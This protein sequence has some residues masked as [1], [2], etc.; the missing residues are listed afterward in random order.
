MHEHGR[1]QLVAIP[2]RGNFVFYMSSCCNDESSLYFAPSPASSATSPAAAADTCAD[3]DTHDFPQATPD[4]ADF[5]SEPE[6]DDDVLYDNKPWLFNEDRDGV[7][8]PRAPDPRERRQEATELH[9]EEDSSGEDDSD[10]ND[11]DAND[12]DTGSDDKGDDVASGSAAATQWRS[13]RERRARERFNPRAALTLRGHAVKVSTLY[14]LRRASR[15]FYFRPIVHKLRAAV[16]C[17]CKTCSA[18]TL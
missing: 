13:T 8:H 12:A 2:R 3:S 1:G 18:A 9:S 10:E 14:N 4:F 15:L 5:V 6:D 16:G 11:S 17:I 7:V